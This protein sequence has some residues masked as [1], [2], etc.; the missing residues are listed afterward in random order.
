MTKCNGK[1]PH[2]FIHKITPYVLLRVGLLFYR[3][4]TTAMGTAAQEACA[5]T[6]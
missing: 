5:G 6:D 4:E 1:Q 2:L 3:E